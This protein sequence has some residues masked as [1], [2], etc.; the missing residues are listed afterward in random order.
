MSPVPYAIVGTPDCDL[1]QAFKV[2]NQGKRAKINGVL[3]FEAE[4]TTVVK[5]I[6]GSRGWS[7]IEQG[8]LE[9]YHLLTGF[10]NEVDLKGERLPDLVVD[11]KRYFMLSFDDIKYQCEASPADQRA[12]RRCYLGTS[13]QAQ[14]QQR[15]TAYFGRVGVPAPDD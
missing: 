3:L 9:G 1:L 5:K 11:F 13:W 4:E 8:R 7:F 14:F 15:A 2:I 10:R 6:V 12:H